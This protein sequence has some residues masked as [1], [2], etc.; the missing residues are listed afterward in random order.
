MPIPDNGDVHCC[1]KV[2]ISLD[3]VKFFL[4]Y[5]AI[6][7]N[8]S[9]TEKLLLTSP[10]ASPNVSL[11]LNL[12]QNSWYLSIIGDLGLFI[13]VVGYRSAQKFSKPLKILI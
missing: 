10:K 9:S 2:K 3:Y 8:A 1:R 7:M 12:T 11:G 5:D 4:D 13:S 6:Y